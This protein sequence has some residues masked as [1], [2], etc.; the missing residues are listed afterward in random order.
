MNLKKNILITGG[1][2]FIGSHLCNRLLNDGN[3]IICL[4][5]SKHF[6][7][8][9]DQ[10][11]KLKQLPIKPVL[12]S[13]DNFDYGINTLDGL[14]CRWA[15]AWIS[16]PK[17]ILEKISKALVPQGKMVIQ[18]YYDWSTHQTKPEMPALKYAIAKALESFKN[19][20][21]EIDI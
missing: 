20:D 18:E 5:K 8:Y 16:N 19:T 12:S 7:D 21:S 3:K 14:Y 11:K 6:I 10:V 4:D 9:L 17:E 15:L 13:F 1:A 2:G